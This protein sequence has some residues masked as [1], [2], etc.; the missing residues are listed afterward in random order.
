[1]PL[2]ASWTEYVP[3]HGQ[4]LDVVEQAMASS[5]RLSS[6]APQAR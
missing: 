3:D 4:M 2:L 6:A 1:M 5:A